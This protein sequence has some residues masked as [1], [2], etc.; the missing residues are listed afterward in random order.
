MFSSD[1]EKHMC[2]KNIR[3][4]K[5]WRD[6]MLRLRKTLPNYETHPEFVKTAQCKEVLCTSPPKTNTNNNV[7]E[8]IRQL[9]ER[10]FDIF[11]KSRTLKETLTRYNAKLSD[12]KLAIKET[13]KIIKLYD[14]QMIQIKKQMRTLRQAQ[15]RAQAQAQAQ[16]QSQAQNPTK[17]ASPTTTKR[18]SP[19]TKKASPPTEFEYDQSKRCPNGYTRNKTS[20]KCQKK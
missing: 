14:A 15:K 19:T 4:N 20:K 2:D 18:A 6:E 3:S 8:E 5:E 17:K 7:T 12:M 1:C 16:A 11:N 13:E 9:E 10:F